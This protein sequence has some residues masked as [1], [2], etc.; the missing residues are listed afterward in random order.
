MSAEKNVFSS[1]IVR[2]ELCDT[3]L[4]QCIVRQSG[5]IFYLSAKVG[6]GDSYVSFASSIVNQKVTALL[7]AQ[8][9]G[10]GKT[11]HDFSKCYNLFAH[12]RRFFVY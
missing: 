6:N 11:E 5:N 2:T 1:D 9:I 10:S 4:S 3:S 7:D 12:N 8:V